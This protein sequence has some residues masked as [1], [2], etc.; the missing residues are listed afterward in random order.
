MARGFCRGLFRRFS[1][2]SNIR[3][4]GSWRRFV[5][6]LL[7]KC[8]VLAV[9]LPCAFPWY[10]DPSR[11]KIT[12]RIDTLF[13][14]TSQHSKRSTRVLHCAVTRIALSVALTPLLVLWHF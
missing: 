8:L 3:C 13:T 2:A 7:K 12:P 1:R 14:F 9:S 10:I 5:F 11:L 6:F 4:F